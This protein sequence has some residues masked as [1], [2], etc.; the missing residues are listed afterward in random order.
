MKQ[1]NNG[2]CL[3]ILVLLIF[4]NCK[5]YEEGP[6]LEFHSV[7]KRLNGVWELEYLIVNG[8]DSTIYAKSHLCNPKL[9]LIYA[10]GTKKS[11]YLNIVN[12]LND[13]CSTYINGSWNLLNFKSEL[14]I[15]CHY[16]EGNNY[17]S[18]GP[19]LAEENLLWDIRKLTTDQ[20]WIDITYRNQYCWAHFRKS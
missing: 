7:C 11:G 1:R 12:G 3:I 5:R 4:T 10:E 20:L 2:K 15:S 6:M 18:I 13:T 17:K 8:S 16:I 9:R 19:F 14:Y